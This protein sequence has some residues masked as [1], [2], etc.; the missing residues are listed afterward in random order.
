[1]SGGEPDKRWKWNQFHC[2][3]TSEAGDGRR[4]REINAKE[5][6][7]LPMAG[8]EDDGHQSSPGANGQAVPC[9]AWVK[10]A[11]LQTI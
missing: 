10:M 11:Y 9:F 2:Q 1:M 8:W 3:A 6:R 4:R 7:R 5:R